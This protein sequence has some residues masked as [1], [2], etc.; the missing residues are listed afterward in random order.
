MSCG[1]LD[2]IAGMQV[3]PYYSMRPLE[4]ARPSQE[5]LDLNEEGYELPSEENVDM[6]EEGY[7]LWKGAIF[8]RQEVGRQSDIDGFLQERHDGLATASKHGTEVSRLIPLTSI[9]YYSHRL[10]R[11]L[12]A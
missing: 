1:E 6:K 5:N 2:A 4:K 9:R 7:E 8:I 10:L 11:T 3:V 12:R